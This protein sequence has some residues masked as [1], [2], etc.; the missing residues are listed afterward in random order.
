MILRVLAVAAGLAGAGTLS[1]FPEFSQQYVQRLGGAVDELGR[2]VA[3][4]DADAAAAGLDRGTALAQLATGGEFGAARAHSLRALVARHAALSADL[5]ALTGAG[6]YGR[7]VQAARLRDPEI[8]ARTLEAFRPALPLGAEGAVFAGAGFALG[9]GLL[10]ALG[11]VLRLLL[12]RPRM[13]GCPPP[14][15]ARR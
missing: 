3:G 5:Q 15:L 12:G 10:A 14:H 11:A 7:A 6:P 13:P 9:W 8:A 4:L 2:V 1:Q